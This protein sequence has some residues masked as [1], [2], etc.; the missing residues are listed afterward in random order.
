MAHF[1]QNADGACVCAKSP[2]TTTLFQAALIDDE[3]LKSGAY[4]C[5]CPPETP[6]W[7]MLPC[8]G[9]LCADPVADVTY[10][11]ETGNPKVAFGGLVYKYT[12]MDS[13]CEESKT[14]LYPAGR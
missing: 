13:G 14:C 7:R 10:D 2:K 11:A 3:Q 9:L 6:F 12:G 8:S 5:Q 4:G 1:I